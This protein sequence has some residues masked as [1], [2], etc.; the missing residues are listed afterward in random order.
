[1]IA[2][3]AGVVFIG[4]CT[5]ALVPHQGFVVG[6]SGSINWKNGEKNRSK[7]NVGEVMNSLKE[8]SDTTSISSSGNDSEDVNM[9]EG[10]R[11]DD[12]DCTIESPPPLSNADPHQVFQ[13][14]S[15][16][17]QARMSFFFGTFNAQL[18]QWFSAEDIAPLSKGFS[19][20][21]LAGGFGVFIIGPVLDKFGISWGFLV[22]FSMGSAWGILQFIPS[23]F[24]QGLSW[25]VF[26]LYRAFFFSVIASYMVTVFGYANMGKVYGLCNVVAAL[27]S[28][29]NNKILELVFQRA[30]GSFKEVNSVFLVIQLLQFFFVKFV[31]TI[32]KSSDRTSAH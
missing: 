32:L 14:L 2:Y 20:I 15:L 10:Q 27:F 1:M 28:V 13:S 9:L 8:H 26:A 25:S 3:A 24:A 21:M 16:L 29:F 19:V 11:S 30:G 12:A 23:I 17:S 6:D 22:T 4:F 31:R 7:C 18:L 5:I